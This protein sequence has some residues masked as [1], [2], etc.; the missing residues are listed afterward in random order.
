MGP[1]SRKAVE[2]ARASVRTMA[3]TLHPSN[4]Q[5]AIVMRSSG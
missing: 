1:D 2:G 5:L 3:R 4:N